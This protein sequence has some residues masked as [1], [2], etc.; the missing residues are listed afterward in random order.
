MRARATGADPYRADANAGLPEQ[1]A[2]P[3]AVAF[4]MSQKFVEG[5]LLYRQEQ[6]FARLVTLSRQTLAN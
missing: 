4:I 3:S 5:L 1:L 2:S 6:S